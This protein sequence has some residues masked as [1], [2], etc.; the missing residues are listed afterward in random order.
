MQATGYKEASKPRNSKMRMNPE[1][2][3]KDASVVPAL[4]GVLRFAEKAEKP[5]GFFFRQDLLPV[6][7]L[8]FPNR[9]L[10]NIPETKSF[11]IG[12]PQCASP[13]EPYFG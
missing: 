2:V 1:S 3:R 8:G 13:N 5:A 4:V 10:K 9:I 12:M 6:H 11:Y 7:L